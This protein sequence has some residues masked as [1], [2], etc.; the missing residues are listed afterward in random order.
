M[1]DRPLP[2]VAIVFA[3]VIAAGIITTSCEGSS[4]DTSKLVETYADVIIVRETSVDTTVITARVDSVLRA[5]NYEKTQ[6][7][8]DLRSMGSDPRTLTSFYDS[9]SQRLARKREAISR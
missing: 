1:I 2:L 4:A 3:V 6:F 5:H 9:V 7:E 8:A